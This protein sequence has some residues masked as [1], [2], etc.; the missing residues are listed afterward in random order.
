[1]AAPTLVGPG[2]DYSGYGQSPGK[3]SEHNT[4]ADIEV[5]YKWLVDTCA[6]KPEDIILYGQSVGSGPTNIDKI[7][8]VKCSV[9]IIHGTA[10]EV[11]DFSHGKKLWGLCKEKYEPLWLNGVEKPL[12]Q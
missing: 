7:P 9:L 8:A 6:V 3:P 5:A 4:Y 2:Y 10:D 11:V 12:S 1:M